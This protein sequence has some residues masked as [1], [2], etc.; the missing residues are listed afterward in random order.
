MPLYYPG[1]GME[2][3]IG[4]FD[5]IDE[6]IDHIKKA[7]GNEDY[8]FNFGHVFDQVEKSIIYETPVK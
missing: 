6:A 8:R 4:D 3:F 7:K 2:D 5:S 1:G